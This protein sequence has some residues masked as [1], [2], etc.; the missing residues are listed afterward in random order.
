MFSRFR[1][2]MRQVKSSPPG[3]VAAAAAARLAAAVRS[4][5]GMTAAAARNRVWIVHGE[6][7]THEAIYIINLAAVDVAN[8]HLINQNIETF[9]GNDRIAFLLLV[10]GHTILKTGATTTGDKD[11][12]AEARIVLL[13]QQLAHFIRRGGSQ[14]NDACLNGSLLGVLNH[15]V[16]LS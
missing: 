10:K 5:E 9:L 7:G 11:P 3:L 14:T 15:N 16:C 12:Q 8:A 1:A 4:L 2:H 13:N 6:T